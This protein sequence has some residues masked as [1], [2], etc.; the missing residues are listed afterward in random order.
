MTIHPDYFQL[1][2]QLAQQGKLSDMHAV[3]KLGI[4]HAKVPL[5][6][7]QQASTLLLQQGFLT[8]A[9]ALCQQILQ[10][11]PQ[12]ISARLQLAQIAHDSGNHLLAR[13]YY[14]ALE[15]EF[16]DNPV[17]QRN[18]LTILEYDP[19]A[20]DAARFAKAMQWGEQLRHQTAHPPLLNQPRPT[21]APNTPIRVGYV[22]ADFCGHTVGLLVKDIITCHNPDQFAVYTYSAGQQHDRITAE[23]AASTH[24]RDVSQ[25]S[26]QAL[27]QQIIADQIDILV[28]LSGHTAGS[29]LSAFALRPARIQ[30]SWLG[31]FATTGLS[32]IDAVF[33]DAWHAPTGTEAFF[34]ETII[35]LP[36]RLC[37]SPPPFSTDIASPPC[38]KNGFVT[39]G[40]FNNTA[41]L[42]SDV[43]ALWADILRSTPHSRLVLK[44][45]TFND[46]AVCQQF[47]HQ[48]A[49]LGIASERVE[50]RP[51]SSHRMMLAQYA[52]I[53]IALDPFPFCGGMTTFEALWMGVPVITLPG[54]RVVSR[55]SLAILSAIG[56]K[57]W[58]ARSPADYIEIAHQLALNPAALTDMRKTLRT[59]L[60]QSVITDQA[61]TTFALEN[62]YRTLIPS[63][64]H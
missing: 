52:D 54:T 38:L 24:F 31:Y 7:M 42:N 16:P 56:H 25:L 5:A 15:T 1:A 61:A 46:P 32:T 28:D 23:I 29:R 60:A 11:C 47:I 58:C 27:A 41:K 12:D 26:D 63:A 53:D 4:D 13:Q 49:Q 20:S 2:R 6:A 34:C 9:Q 37:F 14:N 8:Q 50:L 10:D 30:I 40:S 36:T 39:F 55:Q 33:L 48:F 35:R 19:N 44:W 22:S 64:S 57:E 21:R 43:L 18:S 51:A 59:T 3:L 62:A 45:R 17:I